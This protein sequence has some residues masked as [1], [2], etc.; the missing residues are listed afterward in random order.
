VSLRNATTGEL[1]RELP[2]LAAFEAWKALRGVARPHLR[3]ALRDQWRGLG[4]SLA[5]RR[6][7]E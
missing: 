4:A 2:G 6:A 7:P 1:L 5:E 3:R